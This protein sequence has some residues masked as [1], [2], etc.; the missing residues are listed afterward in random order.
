MA[1]AIEL[2]A[3]LV[4]MGVSLDPVGGSLVGFVSARAGE[5]RELVTAAKLCQ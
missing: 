2:C 3:T 1:L 4:D 5:L